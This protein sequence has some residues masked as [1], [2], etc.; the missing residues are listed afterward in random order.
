MRPRLPPSPWSFDTSGMPGGEQVAA[1]ITALPGLVQEVMSALADISD[2]ARVLDATGRG[3]EA[4][5]LELCRNNIEARMRMFEVESAQWSQTARMKRVVIESP[6]AGE[7]DSN[8]EYARA[9]VRDSLSRGESPIASHLLYTQPGILNDLIPEERRRGI[10]AGL[11]WHETAHLI[12]VYVD[13]G[14]SSGMKA[15]IDVA[16]ACEKVVEYRKIPGI[17]NTIFANRPTGDPT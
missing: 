12:A 4:R 15:A 2:A 14:I 10:D 1:V 16:R 13:R 5:R 11:A 8:V 17:A 7:I 3:A 9:C 6:Y